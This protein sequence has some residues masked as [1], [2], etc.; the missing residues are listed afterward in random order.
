MAGEGLYGPLS[1]EDPLLAVRHVISHPPVI[2]ASV[3]PD[4]REVIAWAIAA[5][6]AERPATA[7]RLAERIEELALAAA[8]DSR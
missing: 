8:P 2:S 6:P 3:D 4:I 1:A 5:N 7:L